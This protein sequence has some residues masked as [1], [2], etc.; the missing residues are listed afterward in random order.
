MLENCSKHT[1]L[2]EINFDG[3]Y[4]SKLGKWQGPVHEGSQA[5]VIILLLL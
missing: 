3:G 1:I 4:N 2:I 5:L